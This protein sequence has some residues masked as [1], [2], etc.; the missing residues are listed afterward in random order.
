MQTKGWKNLLLA[1][2]LIF[3]GA[4][5]FCI[6]LNAAWATSLDEWD[7][8]KKLTSTKYLTRTQQDK[9]KPINLRSQQFYLLDLAYTEQ[10]QLH[11]T[12]PKSLVAQSNPTPSNPEP[13]ANDA[14][15]LETQPSNFPQ[16]LP[17]IEPLLDESQ[18]DYTE[19]LERLIQRLQT[20]KQPNP[21][22][23]VLPELGL[24]VQQIP[25]PQTPLEQLPLP[26]IEET[27]AKFKPIGFLK[28]RIGYFHTSNIFSSNID[29]IEDG[30]IFSGLSLA[31]AY[32]PLGANTYLN[33]SIDGNLIRYIDQSK[34]NYNQVKFNLGIYR[35]LSP[36]LYGEIGWSNQ[37]LFY[38]KDSDRFEAGDRFLGENSLHLSLGRRDSLTENLKL[39]S[40]YTFSVSFA[41]PNNR[42]RIINSLWVSLDYYLQKPLRLGLD[43]QFNLS[44][45]TQRQRDDN[46][47]RLFGHL[48]YQIS[49]SSNIN[50]QSGIS[51]GDSTDNSIDFDGWFF[52]INYNLELGRF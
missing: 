2:L 37:Q 45:F 35:Q 28:A 23:N 38:A 12:L 40:F 3:S 24:R 32:Y 29:P 9:H 16:S 6:R 19:R 1:I 41:E 27:V 51:F 21:K 31:S 7:S 52:S 11:V 13:Q 20:K 46:Y 36:R 4:D 43:Y 48:N 42:N 33:G 39:D 30:L 49:E 5:I 44:D 26:P 8:Q 22:A 17:P 15:Q 47:H 10:I 34:Y 18:T 14:P 50:L 25:I